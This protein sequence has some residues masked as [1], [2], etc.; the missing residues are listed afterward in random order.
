V[1]QDGTY[2]LFTAAPT[3]ASFDDFYELHRAVFGSMTADELRRAFAE[4]KNPCFQLAR[5]GGR[6]VAFK[7]GYERKPGR[8]YSWLG[9]VLPEFRGRGLA[10]TLMRLQHAWCRERGY[11]TVRTHTKNTWK[12]M[13]VLDLKEGFD[14]IGTYTDERGEPK[15]ILE[16]RLDE[17]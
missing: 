11:R 9:G 12:A 3:G 1:A 5:V 14:V 2:E 4:L 6:A 7:V 15:L 10:R 17:A 8:F 16:K 13:L